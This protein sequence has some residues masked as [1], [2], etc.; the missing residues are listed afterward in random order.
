VRCS[1]LL[2]PVLCDHLAHLID[3]SEHFAEMPCGALKVL[4]SALVVKSLMECS[5]AG[6]FSRSSEMVGR[7]LSAGVLRV[8]MQRMW[9][10]SPVVFKALAT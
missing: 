4:R 5:T 3:L 7:S 6:A 1:R 9:E 8:V 10:Q 2:G